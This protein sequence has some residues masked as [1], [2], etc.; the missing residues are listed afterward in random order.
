MLIREKFIFSTNLFCAELFKKRKSDNSWRKFFPLKYFFW[1]DFSVVASRWV[2]NDRWRKIRSWSNEDAISLWILATSCSRMRRCC[3]LKERNFFLI[4]TEK[5]KTSTLCFFIDWNFCLI[6]KNKLTLHHPRSR[7]ARHSNICDFEFSISRAASNSFR[8]FLK[9]KTW[10][11]HQNMLHIN[12][13]LKWKMVKIVEKKT[14][15]WRWRSLNICSWSRWCSSS[16]CA[17]WS[18]IFSVLIID[19]K[20][21]WCRCS[22][23]K[24]RA[25]I[26]VDFGNG[27][28]Q[29]CCWYKNCNNFFHPLFCFL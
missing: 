9:K 6:K 18:E 24:R 29:W 15:C 27:S 14:S 20:F 16:C 1:P 28:D 17:C 2:E 8:F 13:F 7:R 12:C 19:D 26:L 4:K 11:N 25:N 23:A 21:S 10:K 3:S 5:L 22:R